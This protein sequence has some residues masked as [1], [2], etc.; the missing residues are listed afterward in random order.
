M[1]C[2]LMYSVPLKI[3]KPVKR[4]ENKNAY[5]LRKELYYEPKITVV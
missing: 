4:T 2:N 1:G 3:Y 5:S